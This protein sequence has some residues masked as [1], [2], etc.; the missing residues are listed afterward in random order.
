MT[1]AMTLCFAL[2]AA[3]AMADGH[4][5]TQGDPAEGEQQFNRQCVACH[6]VQNEEGEV[7]AGRNAKTGPN[8]YGLAGRIAGSVPNFRYSDGFAELREGEQRW[9]EEHFVAFAQNP[10]DWLR[11]ALD[12]SRARSKMAYQVRQEDQAYDI[13]AYLATFAPVDLDE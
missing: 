1:R 12:D 10:T 5:S 3:P 2:L 7:L 4:L 13:Y 6:V 9:T 8:L 11:E